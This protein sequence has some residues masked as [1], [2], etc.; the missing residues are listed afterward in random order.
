MN[1]KLVLEKVADRMAF[2]KDESWGMNIEKF[3]WT[4]GVGL[5]GIWHTYEATGDEK[6]LTFLKE[7][8]ERH[9]KEAKDKLTVNSTAPLLTIEKLYE[10]TGEKKYGEICL[11]LA[12]YIINHGEKTPEGALGHTTTEVLDAFSDQIWADTMFMSCIF[13]AKLGKAVNEPK[14]IHF[15]QQQLMLHYRYLWDEESCLFYHGWS[16]TLQ[17][18]L[19]AV[20]WGRANAWMLYSTME[21]LSV[22][23]EFEGK[24]EVMKKFVSTVKRLTE[25]Q[26]DN[27]L[28][29]TVLDREDSYNEAS[30]TAGIACAMLKAQKAGYLGEEVTDTIEKAVCTLMTLVDEQGVLQEVSGGTPIMPDVESYMSIPCYAALYGQGLMCMLL[31][32]SM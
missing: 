22:S 16:N 11:E 4:P 12:E 15:A 1:K 27:G 24:E 9:L 17:H 10:V 21:I 32:E 14:Y 23:D 2:V 20:H 25:L 5:Y 30:A 26:R 31:K 13:I 29:G 8:A 28:F 3:D 6:Y 19:S 7:W 18:H